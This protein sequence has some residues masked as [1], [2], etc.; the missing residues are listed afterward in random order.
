MSVAG[1]VMA[2]MAAMAAMRAAV[3]A[4]TAPRPEAHSTVSGYCW[5]AG[6]GQRLVNFNE[7]KTCLL[8]VWGV[9]FLY[10]SVCEALLCRHHSNL[11]S[12]HRI[13]SK[14]P[15]MISSHLYFL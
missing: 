15:I 1:W 3:Q 11:K 12:R 8:F 10:S 7:M 9:H 2:A 6:R 14:M 5:S 13:T 4:V